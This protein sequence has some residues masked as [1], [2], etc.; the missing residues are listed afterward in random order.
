MVIEPAL[1]PRLSKARQIISFPTWGPHL[2]S[3]EYFPLVHDFVGEEVT[4]ALPATLLAPL[5]RGVGSPGQVPA[6]APP[7]WPNHSIDQLDCNH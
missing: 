3:D 4:A 7:A 1:I 2:H 6:I 5:D